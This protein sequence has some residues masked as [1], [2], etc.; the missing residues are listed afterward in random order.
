MQGELTV[1]REYF[2]TIGR[3]LGHSVTIKNRPLGSLWE[4][5][6]GW[7]LTTLPHLYDVEDLRRDVGYVP[8]T[9]VEAA[10]VEAL[11]HYPSTSPDR[12]LTEIPVHNRMTLLPRPK[13]IDWLV[14]GG[15]N[16]Q[17]SIA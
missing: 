8:A 6:H 13:R 15:V 10:I 14:D 16:L 11:A 1:A 12:R 3:L 5:Q 17:K 9:S 7:V 4:E 2:E